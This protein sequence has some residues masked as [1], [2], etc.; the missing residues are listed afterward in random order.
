M[1]FVLKFLLAQKKNHACVANEQSLSLDI[2]ICFLKTIK[3]NWSDQKT[4]NYVIKTA[5]H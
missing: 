1:H 5:H 2:F 3:M 4:L